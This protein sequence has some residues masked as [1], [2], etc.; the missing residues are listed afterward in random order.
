MKRCRARSVVVGSIAVVVGTGGC[1]TNTWGA[2]SRDSRAA[3]D[4]CTLPPSASRDRA[5]IVRWASGLVYL[6]D[7]KAARLHG[8]VHPENGMARVE[9]TSPA[10]G[11]DRVRRGCIIGRIVSNYADTAF[12]F[13][14]GTTYIWADAR[15]PDAVT[16]IAD[17]GT[18]TLSGYEMAILPKVRGEEPTV[19][20][21]P[22][23][24]I[25]GE[26]AKNDWCVYPSNDVQVGT[27]VL[28]TS[29]PD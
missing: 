25:C 29:G 4:A 11:R 26:C 19:A 14:A 9:V 2:F 22:T 13:I 8:F 18:T 10:R 28:P 5:Q 7:P 3:T 1:L 27:V 12:G 24:H 17:D 23:K 20:G 16:L 21:T 15:S 6:H